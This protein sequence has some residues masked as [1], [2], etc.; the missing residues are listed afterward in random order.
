M[1]KKLK[2]NPEK[3][4]V[5]TF[6]DESRYGQKT[7]RTRVWAET[8][9]RPIMIKQ[10]GY[11]NAYIFGVVNPINGDAFGII[12]SHVGEDFMQLFL[13]Q[14]S[15]Q[16]KENQHSIMIV[17]G[18]GWHH[19]KSLIIPENITLH[20]LPAYCPEL[21]PIERLWK[22]IKEHY[23]SFKIYKTCDE[24]LEAGALAWKNVNPEI[25]KSVCASRLVTK[26]LL[27]N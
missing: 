18:A 4:V 16:L 6:Q 26:I 27:G 19:A 8:N 3:E 10:L 2:K 5:I 25:I 9:S 7:Q 22:W 23:L 11:K 13:D 17:D 20:F 15:L 24:I 12:N 14:Y 1:W 21:N